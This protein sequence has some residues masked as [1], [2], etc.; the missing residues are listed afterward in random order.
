VYRVRIAPGV[1]QGD[2]VTL[3]KAEAHYVAHVLRLR[4]GDEL[5]AFDGVAQKYRLRL[6]TVSSTA[7]Q[8]QVVASQHGT[9]A[10]PKPLILG[11]AVPKGTKMDLIVEKCSELGLT[12]LVPLYTKRTVAREVP[13]RMRQKLARWHRIAE[14]A[15]RQCG[16]HT[17]LDLRHPMS[18]ADFCAHYSAAPVKIVC[19]T[20]EPRSGLRQALNRCAGQSPVVILIG[21]EGGWS[22][23]EITMARAHGFAAVHLGPRVLRTETAA[24]VVTSIVRYSLGELEPQVEEG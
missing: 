3:P 5:S 9:V 19:W 13:G 1:Q 16:R 12:T 24:I 22:D 14:A 15:A 21:P 11:Q 7:V 6:T 17:L 20:R 23:Q 4:A 18:L 8:G 2:V 10:S